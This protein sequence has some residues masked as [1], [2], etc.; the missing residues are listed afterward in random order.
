MVLPV[1]VAFVAC[2]YDT[3]F[4]P[5]ETQVRTKLDEISGALDDFTFVIVNDAHDQPRFARAVLSVDDPRVRL[6]SLGE[7]AI[8]RWGMK[9]RALRIGLDAA[10]QSTPDYVAYLNLNLKVHAGQVAAGL[11]AMERHGW[12]AAFGSRDRADGGKR[13]GAGAVGALKSA[14]FSGFARAALPPVR[15]YRDANGPLKIFRP[16][17]AR[18]IADA[19]IS[20]GAFFD[21]EWLTLLRESTY[22]VGVF[23]IE[24]TQRAGSKPPWHLVGH[25]VV[26][27][28][29]TRRRLK[30]G[31]Y[32]ETSAR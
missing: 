17:A 3:A 2:S 32:R 4:E 11:E 14:L 22:A 24:W 23:P 21:C 9:G 1:S 25:S 19:A 18:A 29:R 30:R 13:L 31:L 28:L 8:G 12:D 6:I 16:A 7:P 10:L 26:G 5:V 20:D 27:V 15:P